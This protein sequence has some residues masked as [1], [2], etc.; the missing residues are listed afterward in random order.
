M[1]QLATLIVLSALALAGCMKVGPDFAKPDVNPP[2]DWLLAQH[3][4]V[5]KDQ[6]PP[7]DWWKLL[8][9]PALDRL[10]AAAR[11]QNLTLRT[12][13]ARILEARAQ[14]GIAVGNIYPQTQQGTGS[15]TYTQA[16]RRGPSSPQPPA[17]DTAQFTYWQDTAGFSAAW[18]LDFWG[19]F[20]RAIESDTASLAASVADYD[21]ALVSLSSDVAST[22]VLMR[23]SEERLRIAVNN[24]KLQREALNIADIRF[25]LGATSERDV[26]QAKTL[27][28]STEAN[29][30]V[31]TGSR[32][33]ARNALCALLA[34]P[35]SDLSE[36]LGDQSRIPQCPQQVGAGIPADLLR[37]RPD[38]RKAEYSAAAQ[39]ARIGVAKA[40][41]FPAFSLTGSVGW[42]SSTMGVYNL[43]DIFSAKSLTAG[44]GPSVTWNL[45]NYGRIINNVRVQDARFEQ[46]LLGYRNAVI[47][48]LKEVE[49]NVSDFQQS[50][51]QS[52]RLDQAAQAARRGAELAF[53]QYREGKTD[54]TTVIVAQQDQLTQEDALAVS[55]GNIAL[56]M[57]GLYRSLGGG[58]EQRPDP[59]TPQDKEEMRKR[60]YWG[61]MLKQDPATMDDPAKGGPGRYVPDF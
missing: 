5:A 20:R 37:R 32:D 6:P 61:P 46:A 53:L 17:D 40:D 41:L 33:K 30:P 38:V 25:R 3:E 4:Q 16:S 51:A 31:L 7:E 29:I 35:P 36:L 13:G 44:F 23:V 22:Y 52:L 9:D 57:V 1:R 55:K 54:F 42:L 19:K 60:T 21:N 39:C 14:L 10:V 50:R 15:V 18:E 58:W 59:L 12:A 48:A 49:D 2:A 27:L 26:M 24:V 11:Q 56:G 43:A 45:F 8:N 28:E 34:L 47:V